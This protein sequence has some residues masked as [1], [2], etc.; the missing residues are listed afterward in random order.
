MPRSGREHPPDLLNA[1]E[2]PSRAAER[3]FALTPHA[4]SPPFGGLG[5]RC[6]PPFPRDRVVARG[7]GNGTF[8]FCAAPCI[9]LDHILLAPCIAYATHLHPTCSRHAGDVWLTCYVVAQFCM[10][11]CY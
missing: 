6:G 4:R 10:P 5:G 1:S 2:T 3:E 8:E 11:M 7:G 9:W